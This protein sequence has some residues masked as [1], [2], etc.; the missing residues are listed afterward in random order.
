MTCVRTG[1]SS[2]E[3][4]DGVHGDPKAVELFFHAAQP[5][6]QLPAMVADLPE[7]IFEDP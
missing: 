6:L 7:G 4:E 3:V 2:G 1:G 5:G